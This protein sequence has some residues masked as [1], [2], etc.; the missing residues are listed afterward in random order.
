MSEAS[1]SSSA[2]SLSNCIAK[3]SLAKFNSLPKT[4]KPNLNKEWT[5]LSTIIQHDTIKNSL[6]VVSLGTGTKCLT[7]DNLDNT[8]TK[9]NDSHAEVISRRGFI[10]YLLNQINSWLQNTDC[11]FEKELVNGRLNIKSNINFHFFT[12]HLPCGDASIS[13]HSD[14]GPPDTKKAR[15]EDCKIENQNYD[16]LFF[17][18]ARLISTDSKD[19]MSQVTGYIRTKPGRGTRTLSVSCSD[20]IFRW[21][22]LG[23]QGALLSTLLSNPIYLKSITLIGYPEKTTLISLRRALYERFE[24]KQNLIKPPFKNNTLEI[25]I[26]PHIKF[27]Y[28][29]SKG[30]NPSPNSIVW[31][32]CMEKSIEVAVNGRRLGAT[33]KQKNGGLSISKFEIFKSFVETLENLKNA[34]SALH[35]HTH[36]SEL[37]KLTYEEAKK[38]CTLY[39]DQWNTLKSKCIKTWTKKPVNLQK[40]KIK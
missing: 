7:G 39:Q 8:G 38:L 19:T 28:A 18:G 34:G 31:C 12:S 17:T 13:K 29:Q 24:E 3:I 27:M 25:Y 14:L 33:K 6:T 10:R 11:V 36:I 20:K 21:N 37:K 2:L 35:L 16:E 30:L 15:L 5:V 26:L 9:L 23:I 32:Q 22:L 4:G 1:N 40:F